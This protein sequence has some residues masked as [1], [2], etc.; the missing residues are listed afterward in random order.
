M[1]GLVFWLSCGGSVRTSDTGSVIDAGP[2]ITS[3]GAGGAGIGSGGSA[4]APVGT[5]ESPIGMAG[6]AD[7]GDLAQICQLPRDSGPCDAAIRAYWH[8]P[9]SGVC[10]PFT[11]GGCQGNANRFE[12]A[13]AC[14]VACRG[15]TPDYDGC[16]G[17]TDC[18]VT[19]FACCGECEPV[20][21]QSIIAINKSHV[22]D[23][24]NSMG[25][26]AVG[27][28]VCKEVPPTERT[29][30]NFVAT[31]TRGRCA[32]VD[33]RETELV[34][35]QS[36]TECK[37]RMGAG[38]CERCSDDSVVALNT[39]ANLRDLVCGDGAPACPPCVP[40]LPKGYAAFCISGK[41]Q[42]MTSAP[43]L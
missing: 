19:P 33:I 13:I 4:G 11:Y 40:T 1:W 7:A 35:C 34:A 21:V 15:G 36:N 8:N 41:C 10:E 37:L 9:T 30:P 38:C 22:A 2:I 28:G 5:E 39:G 23:Y 26:A 20:S 12:T 25:C 14:Q 24:D 3:V 32:L 43:S 27:C 29:S 42:V 16:T 6:S 17:P 31:C 18:V